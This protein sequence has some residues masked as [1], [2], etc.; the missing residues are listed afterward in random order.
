ME[1]LN[2]VLQDGDALYVDIGLMVFSHKIAGLHLEGKEKFPFSFTFQECQAVDLLERIK[3]ILLTSKEKIKTIYFDFKQIWFC[4]PRIYSTLVNG[5]CEGY[6]LYFYNLHACYTTLFSVYESDIYGIE[7]ITSDYRNKESVPNALYMIKNEKGKGVPKQQPSALDFINKVELLWEEKLCEELD[8]VS[9]PGSGPVRDNNYIVSKYFDISLLFRKP[10]VLKLF[11]YRLL[12]RLV[13]W[14]Q[15]NKDGVQWKNSEKSEGLVDHSG[16]PVYLLSSSATG[17]IIAN[18]I[19]RY[20]GV[21]KISLLYCGPGKL[22]DGQR[23]HLWYSNEEINDTRFIYIFDVIR[24]GNEFQICENRIFGSIIYA[25]FGFAHYN[26]VQSALAER[27]I[28]TI[29]LVDI[30]KYKEK[31]NYIVQEKNNE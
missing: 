21:P 3:E 4:V 11:I 10:Y 1:E 24:F 19:G 31:L 5:L 28:D 7:T 15:N 27:K 9:I 23:K 22:L 2:Y 20:L 18:I 13:S 12:L 6:V 14:I 8:K 25:N 30:K 26:E 29:S 17:T 16:K